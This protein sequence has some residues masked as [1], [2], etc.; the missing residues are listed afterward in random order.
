MVPT[1]ELTAL[2]GL[3]KDTLWAAVRRGEFPAPVRVGHKWL[4][5]RPTIEA[6]LSGA[7]LAT[8][9]RVAHAEQDQQAA[10]PAVQAATRVGSGGQ[11]RT[12]ALR[13]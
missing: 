5:Y 3:H 4:W 13:V 10:G 7:S 8:A 2:T 9:A 12:A 6:F 1:R 11:V